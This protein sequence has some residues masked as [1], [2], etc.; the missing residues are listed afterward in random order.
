MKYKRDRYLSYSPSSVGLV[1]P[2]LGNMGKV[3]KDSFFRAFFLCRSV[4]ANSCDSRAVTV[5]I[6][7]KSPGLQL[8]SVRI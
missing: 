4:I 3:K 1:F 2:S 5:C 7:G 6:D 8:E